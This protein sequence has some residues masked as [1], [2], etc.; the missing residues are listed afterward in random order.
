VNG[1][2]DDADR[3]SPAL[4]PFPPGRLIG[5]DYGERRVG[6]A[7]SDPTGTIASARC[8]IEWR[9]FDDLLRRLEAL[10]AEEAEDGAI[11]GVVIGDPRHMSGEPSPGSERVARLRT[12]LAGRLGLPVWCWD[13]RLSSVAAEAAL[14][15]TG[16]GGR[17]R[18]RR[19]DAVAAALIL[20]TFLEAV[21][22]RARVSGESHDASRCEEP[23][24]E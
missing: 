6:V 17:R 19:V 10:V 4:P 15:E 13:E 14:A 7:T 22:E 9:G 2:A 3:D 12:A 11:A 1:P 23:S 18:R 24:G 5:L 21:R 16:M 20:Q 8:S